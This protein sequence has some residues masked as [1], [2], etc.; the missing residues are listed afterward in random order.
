MWHFLLSQ[1]K[2]YFRGVKNAVGVHVYSFTNVLEQYRKKS[3]KQFS[4]SIVL[5]EDCL[6]D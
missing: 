2:I 1:H 5:F 6:S 3:D 4:N